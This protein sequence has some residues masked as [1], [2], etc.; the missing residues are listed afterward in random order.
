MTGFNF[1]NFSTEGGYLRQ[2]GLQTNA[3]F[4]GLVYVAENAWE[5]FDIKFQTSDGKEFRERTFGA[6]INKVYPRNKYDK[7]GQ[8]IGPETK[9]EAFDRT[10]EDI[11]RKLW[12][13]GTCFVQPDVLKPKLKG[14]RDLKELVDKLNKAI[15]GHTDKK[16]NFLTIWKNNDNKKRSVLILADK[17]RWCEPTRFNGSEPLPAGIKLTKSQLEKNMEE[18]YPYNG[19]STVTTDAPIINGGEDLPF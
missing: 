8:L 11:A 10:N 7:N 3:T 13:L 16:V 19:N 6:D 4:K 1:D 18:K 17:V 15:E 5:G 2:A 9:Q 14:A 12:Y